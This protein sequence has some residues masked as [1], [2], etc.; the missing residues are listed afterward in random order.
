MTF[1]FRQPMTVLDVESTGKRA[2]LD[3]IV[4]GYVATLWPA[5]EGARVNVDSRVLINPGV[6]SHPKAIEVHGITD[7]VARAKGCDPAEG[8]ESLTIAVY[9]ALAARFPVI[10]FNAPF[11]LGML[12][13]E[14]E[15]HGIETVAQ[16]L[17]C[18]PGSIAPIVDPRVLDKR[19]EPYRPGSRRL[20]P[21]CQRWG[22]R[23]DGAHDADFDAMA[24]GRL[25]YRFAQRFPEIGQIPLGILH[26][27]Q[28]GW[29]REQAA[30]L[31]S[32]F[33]N[34]KGQRDAVVDPCWPLCA[35]PDHERAEE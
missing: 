7:E 24:A 11:D 12:H 33:R 8:I 32:Y 31:Q 23:L 25:A 22:V 6:P 28:V 26:E 4:T 20:E 27:L 34:K 17:G 18:E 9:R 15:R 2:R 29:Y 5:N 13:W 35:N 30:G 14:G 10:A 3:R 21:T 1:W 16:R 19:V